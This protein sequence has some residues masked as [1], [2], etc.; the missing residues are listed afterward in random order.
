MPERKEQQAPE[1]QPL[2]NNGVEIVKAD[3]T[4]LAPELPPVSP[5]QTKTP[6]QFNQ[7]VNVYQQIPPSAWDRLNPE[8]VVELS[9]VIVQQIDVAD[10]RQFD[11]AIQKNKSSCSG[12]KTAI[13]CGSAITIGGFGATIYL[14]MH[15]HELI[16]LSIAL[17][18]ATI[19]A[20]IVGNRFLE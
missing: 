10:K 2:K 5:P 4:G 8:Q 15:A 18:L 16:A 20:V 12:K 9:K 3:P 17:P 7:Q 11:Y 19:L 14:G 1:A 13:V 6:V